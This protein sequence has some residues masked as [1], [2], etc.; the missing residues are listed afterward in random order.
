MLVAVLAIFSLA[1]WY[2][3]KDTVMQNDLSNQPVDTNT[4]PTIANNTSG[5]KDG[6]Y[7]VVS[8][9][10]SPGGK[11]QL[12]VSVTLSGN[13]ISAVTVSPMPGDKTSERYQQRFASGISSV[14]IGQSIDTFQV[15]VVSGASLASN[16][17]N[18]ALAQVKAQAKN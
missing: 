9:Y 8:D 18:Q 4:Q 1:Y 3:T 5:Y 10:M 17:F 13:K 14:A 2:E 15:G 12:G 11:D 7:K 6:T 16:A